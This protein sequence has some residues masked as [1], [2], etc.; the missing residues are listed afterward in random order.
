MVACTKK[1]KDVLYRPHIATDLKELISKCTGCTGP[2]LSTG[3]KLS[4]DCRILFIFLG[5]RCSPFYFNSS[6]LK[7][8]EATFCKMVDDIVIDKEPQFVS[9]KFARF[10]KEWNF[11][12]ITSQELETIS[13]KHHRLAQHTYKQNAQLS[14]SMLN[15]TRTFLPTSEN[16]L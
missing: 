8:A 2:V 6:C 13:S 14:C 16:L 3:Q 1:A 15:I 12:H 10:A 4:C 11:S 5:G 7:E 9:N